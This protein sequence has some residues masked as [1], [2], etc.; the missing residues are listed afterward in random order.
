M[1]KNE[2]QA[3]YYALSNAKEVLVCMASP[4][5]PRGKFADEDL[6]NMNYELLHMCIK[7]REKMDALEDGGKQ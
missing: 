3:I 6:R 1:T 7:V 2:L 4:D 5:Y